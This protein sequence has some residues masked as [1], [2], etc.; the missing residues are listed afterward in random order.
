MNEN[1]NNGRVDSF[2]EY[3]K[4]YGEKVT[5]GLGDR[6]VEQLTEEDFDFEGWLIPHITLRNVIKKLGF[7]YNEIQK[8][9]SI[10]DK[11][12]ILDS[13]PTIFQDDGMGYGANS[14]KLSEV[15]VDKENNVQIWF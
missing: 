11:N 2:K 14:G 15:S 8:K 1:A 3:A 13:Y 12:P 9:W 10:S 4:L 6:T 7:E 5:E